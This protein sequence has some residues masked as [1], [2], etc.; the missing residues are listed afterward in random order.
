MLSGNLIVSV[1]LSMPHVCFALC[2]PCFTFSTN[3]ASNSD[4]RLH[5][6]FLH[7]LCGVFAMHIVFCSYRKI[8]E[9]EQWLSG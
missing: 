7:I 2:A 3:T 1:V 5:V 9:L 4:S 8:P 6:C